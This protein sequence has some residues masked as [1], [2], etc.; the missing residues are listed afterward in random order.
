MNITTA[1]AILRGISL[2]CGAALMAFTVWVVLRAS[3]SGDSDDLGCFAIIVAIAAGM[4]GI[5]MVI[6]GIAGP[7]A[8][9][10]WWAD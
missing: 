7:E 6:G 10:A 4:A 8:A 3:G 1:E 2:V 5:T 9:A